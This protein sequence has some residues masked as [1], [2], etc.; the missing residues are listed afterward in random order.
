MDPFAG[1]EPSLSTS[2]EPAL[3]Q[4]GQEPRHATERAYQNTALDLSRSA[5]VPMLAGSSQEMAGPSIE[6]TTCH[7]GLLPRLPARLQIVTRNAD[8]SMYSPLPPHCAITLEQR[9]LFQGVRGGARWI[10]AAL[11]NNAVVAAVRTEK[12]AMADAPAAGHIAQVNQKSLASIFDPCQPSCTRMEKTEEQRRRGDVFARHKRANE[13]GAWR[14]TQSLLLRRASSNDFQCLYTFHGCRLLRLRAQQTSI[15]SAQL[16]AAPRA[17]ACCHIL[18]ADARAIDWLPLTLH[19]SARTNVLIYGTRPADQ[20]GT[21]AASSREKSAGSTP[22]PCAD[23][24]ATRNE[25][26]GCLQK[27]VGISRH[28]FHRHFGPAAAAAEAEALDGL[29]PP[30][31]TTRAG[32][33]AQADQ[34]PHSSP[35][36]ETMGWSSSRRSTGKAQNGRAC[37]ASLE[38]SQQTLLPALTCTTNNTSILREFVRDFRSLRA[39]EP[40]V[41]VLVINRHPFR[42]LSGEHAQSAPSTGRCTHSD[43]GRRPALMHCVYGRSAPG[44]TLRR[45]TAPLH[46]RTDCRQNRTPHVPFLCSTLTTSPSQRPTNTWSRVQ[47]GFILIRALKGP[48]C[49]GSEL[50]KGTCCTLQAVHPVCTL[51]PATQSQI[52]IR[53]PGFPHPPHRNLSLPCCLPGQGLHLNASDWGWRNWLDEKSAG[54]MIGVSTPRRVDV[55]SPKARSRIL[56][57]PRSA[58]SHVV[59]AG[60]R[61]HTCFGVL[62]ICPFC[63]RRTSLRSVSNAQDRP[64]DTVLTAEIRV[65]E[66]NFDVCYTIDADHQWLDSRK[67]AGIPPA[68]RVLRVKDMLGCY[69]TESPKFCSRQATRVEAQNIALSTPS[70]SPLGCERFILDPK[71]Y[72]TGVTQ[73]SL[74]W[75]FPEHGYKSKLGQKQRKNI[76]P[77]LAKPTPSI[78]SSAHMPT[79]LQ[80]MRI[81][82]DL[83]PIKGLPCNRP[84]PALIDRRFIDV[85][86]Q[87]H[88]SITNQSL[89]VSA[90]QEFDESRARGKPDA[91]LWK[92]R[93][94]FAGS[95]WG[96][97]STKELASDSIISILIQPSSN[98]FPKTDEDGW[99][100]LWSE[101]LPTPSADLLTATQQE[102]INKKSHEH[103]IGY[104][105]IEQG[106]WCAFRSAD[107]FLMLAQHNHV[108]FTIFRL[109]HSHA[110]PSLSNLTV[111][112]ESSIHPSPSLNIS[113]STYQ[114]KI[115]SKR[116]SCRY[117]RFS[118]SFAVPSLS[119][120]IHVSVGSP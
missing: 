103:S 108:R 87:R 1:R 78:T 6:D 37:S 72:L 111:S 8:S 15:R 57:M 64:D 119:L 34:N 67:I 54:F 113:E 99:I 51:A 94:F 63:E 10:R 75:N 50:I 28:L 21:S 89:G 30:A 41:R 24:V 5:R 110:H 60:M 74:A 107:L 2:P 25:S 45:S 40:P 97:T 43:T 7:K 100:M 48:P 23:D 106:G 79:R 52:Y 33:L 116:S 69:G 59:I 71:I 9:S 56:H 35:N 19:Q 95:G 61:L 68:R 26:H 76:L 62:L 44:T 83:S 4:L 70:P 114:A 47:H 82:V 86:I 73:S 115:P 3:V 16:S 117:S 81:S 92:I 66:H 14:T 17:D 20:G 98:K 93:M 109:S 32:R 31:W 90:E 120:Y 112:R 27:S 84:N 39:A 104:S 96:S 118:F 80:L 29:P 11:H 102:R 42:T 38:T 105:Q 13:R 55:I 101:F 18:A 53:E 91:W 58:H 22:T 88:G 12:E 36:P 85:T 49:R 65:L 77:S 46:T